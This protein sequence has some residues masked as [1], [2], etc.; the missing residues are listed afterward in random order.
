MSGGV[1]FIIIIADYPAEICLRFG[2]S[3]YFTTLF[4][5]AHV[6][7]WVHRLIII[8]LRFSRLIVLCFCR[9]NLVGILPEM[10]PLSVNGV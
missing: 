5:F 7:L 9:L 3:T 6:T 4:R 8:E 2:C 1:V 10:S